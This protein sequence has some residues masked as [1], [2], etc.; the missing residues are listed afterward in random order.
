MEVKM[1]RIA[2]ASVSLLLVLSCSFTPSS[3]LG[4]AV[5]AGNLA[6]VQR[7]VAAGANPNP[8]ASGREPSP[9]AWAARTGRIDLMDA[10]LDAGANPELG[11]GVNGWTPLVH[12]V[13]KGQQGA[14]EILLSRTRPG[15]EALTAALSMAAG[16]G[17][18]K[19]VQALLA[20][21]ARPDADTLTGAVGG[22]WDIDAS[23]NGCGPHTES[24]RALLTASP[25]LRLPDGAY[26]RAALRFAEKKGCTEMLSLLRGEV[27]AAR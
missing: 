25:D 23:W 14:V 18:P 3:D 19:T 27:R 8:P 10:L 24:V 26:G 6:E 5:A 22:V 20:A 15:Q 12:A 17:T 9:L 21:G 2:V 1:C 7:L 13:H 16:Y 4:K 11:S